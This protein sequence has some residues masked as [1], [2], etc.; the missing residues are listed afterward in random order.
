MNEVDE[1]WQEIE[2]IY[3]PARA[4]RERA[5][6]ARMRTLVRPESAPGGERRGGVL[7]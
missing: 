1:R 5:A 4:E 3:H 7:M 2:R 6:S